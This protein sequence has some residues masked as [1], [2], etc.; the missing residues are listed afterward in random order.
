MRARLQETP[1]ALAFRERFAT[2]Q[3][4]ASGLGCVGCAGER[5]CCVVAEIPE[6]KTESSLY[7]G[8]PN[9]MRNQR[10]LELAEHDEDG[11]EIDP[12]TKKKKRKK[13]KREKYGKK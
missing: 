3:S 4:V 12:I 9:A 10:L 2:V 6:E 8:I 7:T 11:D 5:G 13:N 1:Q